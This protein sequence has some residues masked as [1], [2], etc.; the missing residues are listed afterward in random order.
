ML[1]KMT[2]A[3]VVHLTLEERAFSW[4]NEDPRHSGLVINISRCAI[5]EVPSYAFRGTLR[6]IIMSEVH[7]YRTSP[8]AFAAIDNADKLYFSAVRFASIDPQTF[9]KFSVSFLIFVDCIISMFPSN[10]MN[11]VVRQEV[12]FQ[13]VTIDRIETSALVIDKIKHFQIIHSNIDY[14][15]RHAFVVQTRGDVS[16][17]GNKFSHIEGLAFAGFSVDSM[18]LGDAGRQ[19]L[20]FINNTLTYVEEA[21]LAFNITGF[22]PQLELI[23]LERPCS[24][25]SAESWNNDLIQYISTSNG[26]TEFTRAETI[27]LCLDPTPIILETFQKT[28]CE[29]SYLEVAVKCIFICGVFAAL[30]ILGTLVNYM[31]KK[32]GKRYFNVPTKIL[33]LSPNSPS[34]YKA[35]VLVVPD[36]KTYRETELHVIVEH[37]EPIVT[38]EFVKELP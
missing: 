30:I 13:N 5:P 18:Y 9:K 12:R 36:G 20:V 35:N 34:P 22:D 14:I 11:V 31:A 33:N 10:S 26:V 21:A 1:Q 23:R 3:E 28:K 17:Y 19:D 6:D 37:L 15:S 16:F 4:T 29:V 8:F 25:A 38:S 27:L 24:C 7:I 2:V 32:K